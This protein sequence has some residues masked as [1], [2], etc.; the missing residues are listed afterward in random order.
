MKTVMERKRLACRRRKEK[1]KGCFAC[2]VCKNKEICPA[3]PYV[4]LYKSTAHYVMAAKDDT[5]MT[6][7][8]LQVMG[9]VPFR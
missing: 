7:R 4:D 9:A 2:K 1:G 8:I 6:L 3:S 5:E